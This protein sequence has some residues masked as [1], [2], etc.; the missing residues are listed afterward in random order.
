MKRAILSI[1]LVSSVAFGRAHNLDSLLAA[2]QVIK[3]TISTPQPR[4][5]ETFQL[6][7]DINHL[8]ANIFR[9]LAGKVRLADEIGDSPNEELTMNV[10]P[11]AKGKNEI[12]P[13]EFYVNKTKYTTNKIVYE[14]I[15]PLPDT[16]NGLWFRTVMTS[17]TTFCIIIE[18]RI[19]AKSVTTKKSDN[20]IVMTTEPD[21]KKIVKFRESYSIDGVSGRNSRSS[22]NFSTVE[23]N[24][25]NKQYMF[26]Y[27]VYYFSIDNRQAK[28]KITQ[29][30]FENLPAGY[31]FKDIIIQ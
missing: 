19:P 8:R 17:D 24:G 20:S 22:T 11:L 14:A 28:I 29:D 30:K 4:L 23:I 18:Q 13:L 25:E 12:G 5:N 2:P 3:L 31:T 27:S 16:D 7:L 6:S 1:L 9:S 10:T 26:G 15:D 21:Y